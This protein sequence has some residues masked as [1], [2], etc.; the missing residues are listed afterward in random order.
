MADRQTRTP[1]LRVRTPAQELLD[2]LGPV[3]RFHDT[4]EVGAFGLPS[5]ARSRATQH[6]TLD[7]V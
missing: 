1:E 5:S 6:I 7:E 4:E 2:A 3:E